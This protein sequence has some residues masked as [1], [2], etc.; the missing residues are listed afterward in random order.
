MR[1][2][3]RLRSILKGAGSYFHPY[4]RDTHAAGGTRDAR[5]CYEVFLRHYSYFHKHSDYFGVPRVVAEIGPGSSLGCGLAAL[6]AGAEQ[7]IALDLQAHCSAH[8]DLE[9]LDE[10]IDLFHVRA[11]PAALNLF[12]VPADPCFPLEF[13]TLLRSTLAPARVAR[14]RSDLI[15][16]RNN[17]VRYV[18][19]WNATTAIA[20][21]SVDWLFSHSVLEHVDDLQGTYASIA[22]WLRPRALT[23]HMIDF[24]SHGLTAEWNGHWAISQPVW[25]IIRGKRPYLINRAWRSRHLDLIRQNGLMIHEEVT[26]AG[27]GGLAIESFGPDFCGMPPDDSSVRMSFIVARRGD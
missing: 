10:L 14:I 19:P 8:H 2:R 18:V 17:Y 12:P 6:L 26:F 20:S 25:R 1:P 15:E 11:T 22:A 23:T 21:S 7:Y 16:H 4:L 13:D 24:A 27:D 5:Y 9:V 3:I